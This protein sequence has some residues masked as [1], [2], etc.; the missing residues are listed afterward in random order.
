MNPEIRALDPD[1]VR[2]INLKLTALAEPVSRATADP[3]F[4]EIVA[5]L[6]RNHLQMDRLLG[7]PLCPADARIQAFLDRML[8]SV[9][10]G[11]AARL[12]ARTFVLDRP[13]LARAL[14]L[15]AT[16][17]RFASP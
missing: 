16:A 11:G 2:Y 5:P 14:S 3:S 6:L 8:A 10:P 1:L 17:D 12:P 4:M 13:G 9:C 7:W 15:P